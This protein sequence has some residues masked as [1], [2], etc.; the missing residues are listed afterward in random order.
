MTHETLREKLLD[1]AYGELPRREAARVERHLE[2]CEPCRA[3][4]AR[5][6]ETRAAMSALGPVPAPEAGERVL[7]AA[8]RDAAD[9]ARRRRPAPLLPAWAWAGAVGTVAVLAVAAV[10]YRLATMRPERR[11][12]PEALVGRGA[13]V[14]E[15]R[16]PEAVAAASRAS[17][18]APAPATRSAPPVAPAPSPQSAPANAFRSAPPAAPAPGPRAPSPAKR[19]D[20]QAPPALADA[21]APRDDAV[22][23][24][25]PPAAAP[26]E[27]VAGRAA[28]AAPQPREERAEKV[29]APVARAEAP[30]RSAA[31]AAED[32]IARWERLERAGALRSTRALVEDCPGESARQ[33]D[34][35]PDGA[36]V[37]LLTERGGAP[38]EGGPGALVTREQFYGADGSLAVVRVTVERPGHAPQV[39]TT[40]VPPP[41]PGAATARPDWWIPR[42][43]DVRDDAPPR[44]E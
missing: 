3:E 35:G 27:G 2:E 42:A 28:S 44:C 39:T 23:F 15:E 9:E 33:V 29:A 32:P 4:L 5:I 10:S 43:R 24:A 18:P 19:A 6:R 1:L 7:L 11:D 37:R 16:E 22:G 13:P 8:A 34:R 20:E 17:P 41:G 25:P 26:A 31:L 14:R 30:T 12:D 36:A 40:R 38:A 21:G